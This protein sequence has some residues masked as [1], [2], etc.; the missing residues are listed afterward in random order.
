MIGKYLTKKN[1]MPIFKQLMI[2][3][4]MMTDFLPNHMTKSADFLTKGINAERN[5]F[6]QYSATILTDQPKFY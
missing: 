6:D 1:T 3:Y 2:E 5:D 4:F